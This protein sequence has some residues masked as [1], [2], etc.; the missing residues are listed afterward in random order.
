LQTIVEGMDAEGNVHRIVVPTPLPLGSTNVYVIDDKPITLIDTGPD[1]DPTLLDL[2][3]GLNE[4]DLGFKDIERILLTHGHVDHC[5]LVYELSKISDPKVL[6]HEQ[7][8]DMIEDFGAASNERFEQCEEDLQ[9][10]GV[11]SQ[12]L[13]VLK[14]FME[15]LE[16][17]THACTVTK[18]RGFPFDREL[19]LFGVRWGGQEIDGA[20]RLSGF[21]E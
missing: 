5:G 18:A 16:S 2:K 11:P 19:P 21:H 12:T 14:E 3:A 6:A 15:F 8:K 10:T 20:G 13:Q 1:T 4:I 7:D 9:C 17:L